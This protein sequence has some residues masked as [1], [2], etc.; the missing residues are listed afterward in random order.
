MKTMKLKKL[1]EIMAC[2]CAVLSMQPAHA[3]TVNWTDTTGFWDVAGNWDLGI[4]TA[5]D[6][7]IINVGGTHTITVRSTGA[8]FTVNSISM[9]GNE[10]LAI[11]GNTLTINGVSTLNALTHTAGILTGTGNVTVTGTATL[12]GGSHQGAGQTLIGNTATG[13]LSGNF[14]LDSGRQLVNNSVNLNATAGILNLNSANGGGSGSFTNNGSLTVNPGASFFQILASN[15]G[16]ADNGADAQF[17]NAGTLVKNGAGGMFIDTQFTNA[18]TTQ[19]QAGSIQVRNQPFS[20]TGTISV[21][22][23]ATFNVQNATFNNSGTL[24]GEGTYQTLNAATALVNAGA[25]LPGV[26]GVG[27][28]TIS[29]DYTQTAAGFFDVELTSLTSFD[30]LNVLGDI[31]LNGTLRVF[32]LGGFNPADGDMFTIATFDDGVTDASDLTGV[33]SNLVW[34]GFDPGISFTASYFDHSIVLNASTAVPVPPALWLLGSG[35]LGLIGIARR[36]TK[37]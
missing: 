2:T 4:P 8:P 23:G 34:S 18:G 36:R 27:A 37:A 3:V 12:S 11:T 5:P 13:T 1:I 26:G 25:L 7:A 24:Q 28:L 32:S 15:F 31:S 19:V 35:I 30:T 10:T 14:G 9:T 29:G 17:T 16:A 33:F 6:D 21:A 22:S 20:N